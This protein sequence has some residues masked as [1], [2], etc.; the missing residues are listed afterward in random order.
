MKHFYVTLLVP[1]C[2]VIPIIAGFTKRVFLD[3]SLRIIFM[4]L[5]FVATIA[6][7]MRILGSRNINNLPLL[8]I[9]TL[10]EFL[11]LSGFFI[12]VLNKHMV[13]VVVAIGVLFSVCC[14]FNMAY[15]QNVYIYNSYSRPLAAGIIIFYAMLYLLRQTTS[16]NDDEILRQ[17]KSWIVIG[18]LIY[19]CSSIFY[20]AFLKL[21]SDSA[22]PSIYF[23]MGNIHASLVLLMYLLFCRAFLFYQHER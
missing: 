20:F 23:L 5:L 11:F 3:K 13:P 9:Y 14:I 8:H 17:P 10:A 4:Y 21:L 6:I 15:L 12:Y 7:P 19:F 2:V 18:L 22:D 16:E 1:L